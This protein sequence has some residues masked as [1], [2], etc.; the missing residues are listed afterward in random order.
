MSNSF[1]NESTAGLTGFGS[2]AGLGLTQLGVGPGNGQYGYLAERHG[3]LSQQQQLELMDVLE[4]EGMSDI[5]AYLNM[6]STSLASG[7]AADGNVQWDMFKS[8]TA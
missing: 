4:N 2:G 8:E 6:G 5:D 3:S 7:S 1:F